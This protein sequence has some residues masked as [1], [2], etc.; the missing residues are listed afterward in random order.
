MSHSGWLLI[1]PVLNRR[2]ETKN[3]A[4]LKTTKT[5][6]G[7]SHQGRGDIKY[8]QIQPN[9]WFISTITLAHISWYAHTLTHLHPDIRALAWSAR[10]QI[11]STG[12]GD[13][14]ALYVCVYLSMCVYVRTVH[15]RKTCNQRHIQLHRTVQWSILMSLRVCVC[16]LGGFSVHVCAYLNFF[17]SDSFCSARGKP[18]QTARADSCLDWAGASRSLTSPQ[19]RQVRAFSWLSSHLPLTARQHTTVNPSLLSGRKLACPMKC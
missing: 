13:A 4:V 15:V 12:Q 7:Q 2:G 16:L 5:S 3:K 18:V 9:R 1:P 8:T 17:F 14:D 19:Q 6:V 11:N 10:E